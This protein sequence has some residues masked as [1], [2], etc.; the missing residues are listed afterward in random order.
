MN[1]EFDVDDYEIFKHV[2]YKPFQNKGRDFLLSTQP[3]L[4]IVF[5]DSCNCKCKFCIAHL[6]HKKERAII[7]EDFLAKIK[8]AIFKMGV[9]E[10]LLLGGEPTI[11]DDI[12]QIIDYLKVFYNRPYGLVDK[13][14]I[15]TN[16]HRLV[17]D[18][19]Y[20]D[21]LINSGITH[22]NIS[23]MSLDPEKQAWINGGSKV[24]FGIDTLNII[25]TKCRNAGV[26]LRINNNVFKKNHDSVV[27]MLT[28]YDRVKHLCNSVKF[29]PL[30]K[31]DSFSTV[32]V[33]T[34]FNGAHI[35]SDDEYDKLWSGM[36][37]YFEGVPIVHNKLTFGFVPYS[38]ILLPTPIILN[39][40]Q[41]GKLREKVVKEKKINNLKLLVTGDLSLS[42][43]REESDFFI[44]TN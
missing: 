19:K 1:T 33:V 22:M 12:F 17:T 36:E 44:D 20:A 41:H 43:N 5:N 16:G 37:E 32:N 24:Y 7:N 40:N 15:T 26:M 2:T 6:V 42:W 31:T 30:L 38:M 8:F 34:A 18:E 28:F 25:Y 21:K 13:I 3:Y 11:N 4:D 35:L 9:R 10:V 29:S 27:D 23:L 39:H 14:C